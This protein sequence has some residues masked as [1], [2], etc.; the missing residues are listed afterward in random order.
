[1][2]LQ[3]L[4][5][6]IIAAT[7][8]ALLGSSA[9]SAQFDYT[10]SPGEMPN[11][12]TA[13]LTSE[14]DDETTSELVVRVA[15]DYQDKMG[16]RTQAPQQRN[17]K[18]KNRAQT[19]VGG[20]VTESLADSASVS[21]EVFNQS[22]EENTGLIIVSGGDGQYDVG[23]AA[24]TR[25]TIIDLGQPRP[26]VNEAGRPDSTG[27]CAGSASSVPFNYTAVE[28]AVEDGAFLA[29]VLAAKA[30]R[31][32]R[33][34]VISGYEGCRECQRY[35]EGFV[36]GVHWVDPNKD[37][38]VDYLADNEQDGFGDPETARTFTETFLDVY[39][40]TVLLPIGRAA[41]EAMIEAACDADVLTI[42]VGYDISETR[43]DLRNCVMLAVN[44]D[45]ERA[46]REAMYNFSITESE[47]VMRYDL[48]NDAVTV[49]ER[50]QE[51]FAGYPSDTIDFYN[52]AREGLRSGQIKACPDGCGG[53]LPEFEPQTG[54]E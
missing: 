49:S 19:V 33:L 20:F 39:Q 48:A 29:G 46:I 40:P 10:D 8:L 5:R 30:S 47:R 54:D 43:N 31:G 44:K 15:Q 3:P 6:I 41:N 16:A 11:L 17:N 45:V 36:N 37:V 22:R 24:T 7:A 13:V 32:G 50:W 26:C 53:S 52:E 12:Q 38:V 4:A 21:T 2:R 27:E 51:R 1:M 42:S 14:L 28:F 35:V 9:A 18:K 23:I 34:G 25:A